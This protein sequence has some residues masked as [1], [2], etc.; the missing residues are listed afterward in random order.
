[1]C[2]F[3]GRDSTL[4]PCLEDVQRHPALPQNGGSPQGAGAASPCPSQDG[5]PQQV[6]AVRKDRH[7]ARRSLRLIRS[8][9]LIN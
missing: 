6:V 7:A 4:R 1:M 2:R 8:A 5:G 3:E 9:F